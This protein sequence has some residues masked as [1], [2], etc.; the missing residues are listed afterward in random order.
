LIFPE[1]WIVEA[2]KEEVPRLCAVMLLEKVADV[3][4]ILEIKRDP[5]GFTIA[6]E[7]RVRN[8]AVGA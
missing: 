7:L 5:W 3:A 4:A 1:S 6:V 2:V 8:A